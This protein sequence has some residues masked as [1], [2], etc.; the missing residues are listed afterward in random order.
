MK[1]EALMRHFTNKGAFCS[2]TQTFLTPTMSNR[3][4]LFKDKQNVL[5]DKK[6]LFNQS[7]NK[8]LFTSDSSFCSDTRQVF[9]PYEV[10]NDK[11]PFKKTYSARVH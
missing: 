8:E 4:T 11:I 1:C 5:R 7:N 2:E 6:S 9:H 10:P 3:K